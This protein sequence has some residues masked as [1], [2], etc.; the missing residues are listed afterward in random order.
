MKKKDGTLRFCIDYRKLNKVTIKNRYPLSQIDQLFDHFEGE[1]MFSKIDVRSRYHQVQIKEEDIYKIK[2]HTR[3][4]RYDFGLVPFDLTNSTT[5]FMCLMNSVL[6]LYLEKLVIIF[7]DDIFIY[8]NNEEEHVEHLIVVLRLLRE[9][10][11]Y[12]NLIKC[13]FFQTKVYYFG[14]ASKEGMVV[15]LENIRA[16]ME[17]E[18]PRNVDEGREFMG[19]GGYDKQFIKNFSQIAYP[20]TYLWRK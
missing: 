1:V 13:N 12:A 9:H 18:T 8:Y 15:G 16:I 20:I 19:L 17:W 3:Y 6:R 10:Q 14:H 4:G 7:I 11:L 2:F 5:I